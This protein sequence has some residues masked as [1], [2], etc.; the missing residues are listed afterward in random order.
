MNIV[1]CNGESGGAGGMSCDG[2]SG[3]C[4]M[5]CNGESGGACGMSCNGKSGGT[6]GIFCNGKSGGACGM[7]SLLKLKL[8]LSKVSDEG[9]WTRL[10]EPGHELFSTLEESLA[11]TKFA[12]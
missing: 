3:A 6:C 2:K 11:S 1:S 9:A 12:S 5:S 8:L 4:S 7:S 10:R